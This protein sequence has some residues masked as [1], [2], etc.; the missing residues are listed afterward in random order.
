MPTNGRDTFPFAGYHLLPLYKGHYE[1]GVQAVAAGKA[2]GAGCGVNYYPPDVD[3]TAER[4]WSRRSGHDQRSAGVKD[5]APS[6][7][8]AGMPT[9][10]GRA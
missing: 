6:A 8:S 4:S 9:P 3:G 7:I 5:P 1:G 10:S 2:Y